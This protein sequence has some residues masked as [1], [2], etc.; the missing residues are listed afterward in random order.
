M[1]HTGSVVTGWSRLLNGAKVWETHTGRSSH[2]FLAEECCFGQTLDTWAAGHTAIETLYAWI[3]GA[4]CGGV[5][6]KKVHIL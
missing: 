2:T 1:E 6:G 4:L 3:C 5:N